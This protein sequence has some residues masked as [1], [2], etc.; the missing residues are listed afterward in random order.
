MSLYKLTLITIKD[1]PDY[2]DHN[3][4]RTEYNRIPEPTEIKGYWSVNQYPSNYA[5]YR[6]INLVS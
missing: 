4:S 5:Q 2:Y 1:I 6:I 3:G